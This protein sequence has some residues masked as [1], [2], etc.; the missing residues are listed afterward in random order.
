MPRIV[1]H[2][3]RR[4]EIVHGLWAVIHAQGLEGVTFRRV[5]EAA[6]ISTG[7]IQHYFSSKEELVQAGCTHM[8]AL[9][10]EGHEARTAQSDPGAALRDLLAAPIPGTTAE[11]LGAAVW[12]AYLARSA[13]D[14]R[15]AEIVAAALDDA[16]DRA[17]RLIADLRRT[18]HAPCPEPA[19]QVAAE[20]ESLT[21]LALGDGL[22]QRVVLGAVDGEGARRI[23]DQELARRG[24]AS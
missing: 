3:D 19:A 23:L 16:R 2:E 6:G 13:S 24:L 1:D 15:I 21:L 7:R 4:G 8:V 5:A 18:G 22:A 20:H 10:R 9:A 11:R 17:L 14:P 12:Y